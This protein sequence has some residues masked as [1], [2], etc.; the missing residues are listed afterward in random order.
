MLIVLFSWETGSIVFEYGIL[1]DSAW[2]ER[3]LVRTNYILA[4]VMAYNK[5]DD[6]WLIIYKP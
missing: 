2:M 3:S 6:L 4:S 1:P 5:V